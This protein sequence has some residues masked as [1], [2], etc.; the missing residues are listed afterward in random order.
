MCR[1]RASFPSP[2]QVVALSLLELAL[3]EA[4]GVVVIVPPMETL[5]LGSLFQS[6]VGQRVLAGFQ[7]SCIGSPTVLIQLVG[8]VPHHSYCL[9]LHRELA[10]HRSGWF[11]ADCIRDG[12]AEALLDTQWRMSGW[13][14][15]QPVHTEA[16][17]D[18]M[19]RIS[20]FDC[21]SRSG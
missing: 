1:I 15:S 11:C 18:V 8:P 6:Q 4:D 19:C 2:F 16:M 13:E 17:G 21:R 9:A 3:D 7:T 5:L 20:C 12:E 10:A 14:L